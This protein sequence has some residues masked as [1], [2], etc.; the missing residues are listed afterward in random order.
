MVVQCLGASRVCE[1]FYI[2]DEAEDCHGDSCMAASNAE[3]ASTAC[4]VE[5]LYDSADELAS[6]DGEDLASI[7]AELTQDV[8]LLFE[9]LNECADNVNQ[10]EMQLGE[11]RQQHQNVCASFATRYSQAQQSHGNKFCGTQAFF[12]AERSH[13]AAVRRAERASK[14]YA[15]AAEGDLASPAKLARACQHFQREHAKAVEACVVAKATMQ[16]LEAQN[17]QDIVALARPLMEQFQ[18]QQQAAA[19]S[20]RR[21]AALQEQLASAKACYKQTM[22]ELECISLSVHD[23]RKSFAA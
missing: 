12:A 6:T 8:P 7:E 5:S 19:S 13:R 16:R 11:A 4:D 2:G 18:R 9:R 21:V 17:G 10:L 14:R 22:A 20:G 1:T 3:T 15:L 23:A